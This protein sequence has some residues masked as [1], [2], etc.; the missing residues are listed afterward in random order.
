MNGKEKNYERRPYTSTKGERARKRKM[1]T[2][3]R[4]SEETEVK[5]LPAWNK[6]AIRNMQVPEINQSFNP[7]N[8]H[9]IK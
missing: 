8:G 7:K 4:N 2:A 3:V 6:G 5:M 1:P 9:F